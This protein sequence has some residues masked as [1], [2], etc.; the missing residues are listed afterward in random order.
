MKLGKDRNINFKRLVIN[1]KIKKSRMIRLR[2][3][4]EINNFESFQEKS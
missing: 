1:R 4:F 3:I 2:F